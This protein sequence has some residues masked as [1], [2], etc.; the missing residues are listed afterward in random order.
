M[1]NNLSVKFNLDRLVCYDEADGWGSA[2]PYMWTV[3]FKI[4]GTTCHLNNSLMLEGTA[5]VF[6]TPGSHGN[7]GDTDVDG[8]DTVSIPSA[9]G[10]QDMIL[11]PI[12]VPDFVKQAGTDDVT[13]V[14]GCIIVLMEE[15]NVSDSGAEA[16]HQ[17]LN[18]A[19]QNALDSL[20]PTLGFLNQ[21]ISDDDINNLTSQIQSQ[22]EDAIKNQQNFFSNLW[23]WIN[24]DDTIGTVVWKF[25]GD[26]LLNQNPVALQ[27]RW[28]NEQNKSS[29]NGDWELFGS[30]NT[31]ELPSCPAEVVK[32]LFEAL[33]G[34]SSSEKSMQYMYNFRNKEMK[35]YSGLNIWWQIAIR[36]SHYLKSALKNKEASEAAISLFRDVP[37]ILNSREKPLSEKHFDHAT[38]VLKHISALNEKDRQSRKDIKRSIDALNMLRGRTPN[39]IFEALA[40]VRPAR[41]PSVHTIGTNVKLKIKKNKD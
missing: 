23:S 3:F 11:T 35:K 34:K 12:S 5:T 6:T 8:G 13:A 31:E 15:D 38:Q 17:A 39:Q 41:Y 2:E 22:V 18:T 7:L 30:I 27:Q 25:S 20:I 33:F 4:D 19:V 9:I 40:N 14:A 26:H 1:R 29:D 32:T 16:G 21:E 28:P 36:N 10:F 37:D 24:K